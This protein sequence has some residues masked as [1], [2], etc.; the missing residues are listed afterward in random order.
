MPS[1]ATQNQLVEKLD[2]HLLR[3]ALVFICGGVM[4]I[5]DTTIVNV[6]IKSLSREFASPLATVQGV[7]T[8]YLLA[9]ATVIPITGWGADRFGT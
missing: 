1:K 9:L 4:S 6:S 2:L 7:S 3:I 5:L 8:A